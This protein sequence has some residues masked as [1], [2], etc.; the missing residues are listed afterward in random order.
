MRIPDPEAPIVD[1]APVPRLWVLDTNVILDWLVFDDPVVAPLVRHV[2]SG[3]ATLLTRAD[4]RTEFER[5]LAYPRFRRFPERLATALAR[6]DRWHVPCPDAAGAPGDHPVALP[7]CGDPDDQK[8]IELA[9][10]GAAGWLVSK[11]KEVL[12]L[13][14]RLAALLGLEVLTPKAAAARLAAPTI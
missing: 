14:R 3:A 7:Q 8:F 4:C 12:R 5:V 11:D 2:E 13:G 1:R 9:R 6:Y 10:D